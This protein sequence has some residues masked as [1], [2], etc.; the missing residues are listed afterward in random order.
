MLWS[1]VVIRWEVNAVRPYFNRS[2]GALLNMINV[3][4]VYEGSQRRLR[5]HAPYRAG[6]R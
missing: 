5:Q 3:I 2:R 4:S 6:Q 1:R